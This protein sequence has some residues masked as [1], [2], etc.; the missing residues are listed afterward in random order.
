MLRIYG[1]KSHVFGGL[2]ILNPYAQEQ[3]TQY[4]SSTSWLFKHITTEDSREFKRRITQA[5]ENIFGTIEAPI[6]IDDKLIGEYHLGDVQARKPNS[7]LS[8][9]SMADAWHQTGVNPYGNL[10][11]QTPPFRL[12]LGIVEYLFRNPELLEESIQ[13]ALYDKKIRRDDLEFH[14][15]VREWSTIIDNGG[16]SGYHRQFETTKAF[17]ADRLPEGMRKS[18]ELIKRLSETS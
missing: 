8:L 9:L 12:R 1:G 2:A 6:L 11:C 14:T 10:I 18:G 3:A 4:D 5:G 7:H 17:F 15:A 16:V 13:A